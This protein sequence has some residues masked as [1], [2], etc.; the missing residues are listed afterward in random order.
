MLFNSPTFVLFF[1]AVFC[2]YW[3]LGRRKPQN[4]LLLLASYVF[5]GTWSWKFLL[6][7]WASTVVD[8]TIGRLMARA[9]DGRRRRALLIASVAVNLSFLGFFKY[10][11]FFVREA[12]DLLGALG[13][14]AQPHIL[15]IVLPVG[16]SFYTFQSLGYVID[17]YRG[18][19]AAERDFLDYALFVAFFP[20]LV[21]GPIE[22]ATHMLPQ[23]KSERK[24][25]GA[26]L[27][28]GLQLM[29]WGLFKKIVIADNLAP[30]V[31][32][33]FADPWFYSAS[34]L[35]TAVVFFAFQI[36]CD[37]SG[38]SDIARGAARTLG[39]DLIVNFNLP[40]FSRSPVE[41]WRR[42]HIS[43]SQWFQDYL[44]FPLAM[45]YVRKGGWASK[46][47]AHVISMTLIGFWHGAN[48]T[49]LMFGVYWGLVIAGYMYISE[50]LQELDPQ[51]R[52]Q[53]LAAV[54]LPAPVQSALAVL[55][56]FGVVCIGWIL[57]RA[58]S[59]TQSW[60]I[61]TDIVTFKPGASTVLRPEVI[62]ARILWAL[63][64]GSWLAEFLY[65]NNPRLIQFATGGEK[66]RLLW[67][68]AMFCAILLTYVVA[69]QGR[70]QPF[71]Y[72]QF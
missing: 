9:T 28:S 63:I 39:F 2:A 71:I 22:R 55:T 34:T 1:A 61:L 19:L 56:M 54:A 72:F 66:R 24:F 6:L 47:R 29:V 50:Q 43:L 18:K 25:A 14:E 15:Q 45:R 38:Y 11:N 62:E 58:A 57:F 31:N 20:Q 52:F 12:V 70:I 41:F 17:V 60:T 51:S 33:V 65:R 64:G 37:F 7:L 5:Y 48:L 4:I 23:F 46:Y 13:F 10:Y 8:Y 27:D 44:Y 32:A 49:F 21:A 53:R 30:Y 40:Y 68:H 35:A 26:A 36:Y 67:R 16:I 42:W 69:Q 59:L 3:G